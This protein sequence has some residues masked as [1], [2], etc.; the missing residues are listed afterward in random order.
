MKFRNFLI[1]ILAGGSL[2][3]GGS[4][5]Y[6]ARRK[7]L[8]QARGVRALMERI[9]YL[10]LRR[11]A[12]GAD[13]GRVSA[14]GIY[15]FIWLVERVARRQEINFPTFNFSARKGTLTSSRLT[16]ILRRMIADGRLAVDRN[17][18]VPAFQYEPRL[19]DRAQEELLLRIVVIIDEVAGQWSMEAPEDHLVRFGKLFK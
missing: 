16:Y 3:L 9:V 2:A 13:D 18:L 17:H 12:D 5:V 10:C 11:L 8:D 6:R 15:F 7:K 14:S 1:S 19:P 4:L